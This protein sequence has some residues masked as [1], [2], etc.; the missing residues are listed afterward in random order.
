MSDGAC[1]WRT[2]AHQ[3]ICLTMQSEAWSSTCLFQGIMHAWCCY[4]HAYHDMACIVT[5]VRDGLPR[6]C[7]A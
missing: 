2:S 6:V 4:W 5:A 3:V 7:S 1:L